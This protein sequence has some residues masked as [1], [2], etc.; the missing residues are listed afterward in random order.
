M[1]EIRETTSRD[2]NDV[3]KLWADGDVMKYV[4]FPDGLHESDEYMKK[5]LAW[6]EQGKPLQNHYSLFEDGVYCGESFYSID[7]DHD[8][9]A[10]L[11]IKLFS[12]ARGKGIGAAGLTYAIQEAF[13][14]GAKSVW[15]DP[16]RQNAKAIAMYQRMGF[17]EKEMPAHIAQ[18]EDGNDIVYM[19]LMR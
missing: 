8:N 15:V 17:V 2:L 11:D 3:Q 9:S 5:W 10:T 18:Q 12:F 1:V 4:G 14:N 16:N 7:A 19:E 13:A 6:I